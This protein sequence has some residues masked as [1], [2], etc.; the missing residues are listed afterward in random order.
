MHITK[1][2]L[3]D[4]AVANVEGKVSYAF[5]VLA[6][7]RY[8]RCPAFPLL[9]STSQLFELARPQCCLD[10]CQDSLPL[11]LLHFRTDLGKV[12]PQASPHRDEQEP[13]WASKQKLRHLDTRPIFVNGVVGRTFI[14]YVGQLVSAVRQQSSGSIHRISMSATT[15]FCLGAKTNKHAYCQKDAVSCKML[16]NGFPCASQRSSTP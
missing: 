13:I 9:I 12:S 10:R 1:V 11:L 8:M 2:S 5:D 14:L 15:G 3:R 4:S 16:M 6:D 7:H